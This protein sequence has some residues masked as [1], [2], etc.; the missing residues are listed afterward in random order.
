MEGDDGLEAAGPVL[1]EHDL[2]VASLVR[3]EQGVQDAVDYVGHGG[4][5]PVSKRRSDA[6]PRGPPRTFWG[7]AAGAVG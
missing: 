1:A 2:L 4:D 5:S 6:G 7:R 3:A